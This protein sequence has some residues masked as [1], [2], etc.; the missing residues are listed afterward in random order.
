MECVFDYDDQVYGCCCISGHECTIVSVI[1]LDLSSL[2]NVQW[3]KQPK[4]T[5]FC[6]ELNANIYSHNTQIRLI[7]VKRK[8]KTCNFLLVYFSFCYEKSA[9]Q[10]HLSCGFFRLWERQGR[11][12]ASACVL[13]Y[14][15]QIWTA[16]A[17][18]Y[19]ATGL[20]VIPCDCRHL[21][22]E[23]ELA[24]DEKE[25]SEFSTER[26]AEWGIA[27]HVNTCEGFCQL[28]SCH[29]STSVSA[30]LGVWH[31]TL[32]PDFKPKQLCCFAHETDPLTNTFLHARGTSCL[33]RIGHSS[34]AHA[35]ANIQS[36]GTFSGKLSKSTTAKKQNHATITTHPNTTE[37]T[38]NHLQPLR[39]S[40]ST[41]NSY[42]R[43]HTEEFK[44][45]KKIIL[46]S[47]LFQNT[48]CKTF[49]MLFFSV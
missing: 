4:Y 38:Y 25:V 3:T 18:C 28:Q 27:H 21:T 48:T 33:S 43:R 45:E 14:F 31:L 22:F 17:G 41:M 9:C 40:C 32:L 16:G 46:N 12:W 44:E 37:E 26:W 6:L 11:I 19:C 10:S 2:K 24:A 23:E 34:Q 47:F 49:E 35:L 1:K 36:Q 20:L 29:L 13:L 15:C 42:K 30:P 39:N 8:W 5:F 7:S